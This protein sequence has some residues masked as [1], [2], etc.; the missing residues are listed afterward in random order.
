MKII[1]LTIISALAV[2]CAHTGNRNVAYTTTQASALQ[3][4]AKMAQLLGAADGST[5]EREEMISYFKENYESYYTDHTLLKSETCFNDAL[6]QGQMSNCAW[7]DARR[8]MGLAYKTFLDSEKMVAA[9]PALSTFLGRAKEAWIAYVPWKCELESASMFGGSAQPMIY[10]GCMN[11]EAEKVREQLLRAQSA[12]LRIKD[13]ATSPFLVALEQ[14]FI[15]TAE[16]NW[17]VDMPGNNFWVYEEMQNA[18]SALLKQ[19]DYI[20]DD[21]KDYE[22]PSKTFNA[23]KNYVAQ[24]CGGYGI[25]IAKYSEKKTPGAQYF[26]QPTAV[27]H[28]ESEHISAFANDW[29]GTLESIR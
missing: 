5:T 21:Y 16:T 19:A 8:E 2:S 6:N 18:Y 11:T 26:T 7:L 23:W 28:C 22:L 14:L 29:N 27:D 15:Q 9:D 24:Y 3:A 4:R 12:Y 17:N 13:G 25:L 20:D 10:Y 1:I